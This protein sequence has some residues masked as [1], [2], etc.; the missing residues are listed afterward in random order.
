MQSIPTHPIDPT[1]V[2][3]A[4]GESR[5][6]GRSKALL[7]VP[8]DHRAL[9]A[10]IAHRLQP[11]RPQR[12]VI[13]TNDPKIAALTDIPGPVEY[14]S[15]RHPGMG[16]LGGIATAL[17]L[18]DSWAIMVACDLPFVAPK[19]FAKLCK[20]AG[21]VKT[22]HSNQQEEAQWDA[23]VP[24][25]EGYAQTLHALYHRRCLPAVETLLASGERKVSRF[26]PAVRVRSVSEDELRPYDSTLRS[27]MNVNTPEEWANALRIIEQDLIQ[28]T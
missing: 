24:F 26:F 22:S 27:F 15:D 3:N 10:H 18:C 4:G 12:I 14:I 25:V 9:I 5:R 2:I 17:S 6:M 8:P 1:L 23:V 21:E 20:I 28:G 19:L 11:L 13:V 7:P 16:A